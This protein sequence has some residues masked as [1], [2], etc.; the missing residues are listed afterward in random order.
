MYDPYADFVKHVLANGL[1]V[2]SVSWDRP[3]IGMEIVVHS[4][5]REDPVTIPGLALRSLGWPSRVW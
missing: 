5:G 3:W 4:G 2:H 1:E